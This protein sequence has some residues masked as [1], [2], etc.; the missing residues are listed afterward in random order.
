MSFVLTAAH[1]TNLVV[2]TQALH[3]LVMMFQNNS[4]LVH[5]CF[6]PLVQGSTEFFEDIGIYFNHSLFF[7]S[8]V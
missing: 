1:D 8:Q 7:L 3:T 4:L 2:V 5:D 6:L